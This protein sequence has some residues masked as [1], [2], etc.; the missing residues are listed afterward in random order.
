MP[1]NGNSSEFCGGPNRLNIYNF[2]ASASSSVASSTSATSTSAAAAPT[3]WTNL[4]CYTDSV[5][6]RTLANPMFVQGAMTVE[7]CTTACQASG[8]ILSG[9][10]YAGEC[11]CD[12]TFKNGGGP[13]PDGSTGCNMPCSGN[14]A[15][16][17][18]GPNRLNMYSFGTV[19]SSVSASATSSSAS[20]SATATGL[21]TGWA[22][23]GCYVDNA[24]GRILATQRP[25][26]PALTIESC[27]QACVGL[28][29]TVAG[30][31]YST[32]CFC[33][34]FLR[35]GGALASSD[36]Q[37]GMAC[38]GNSAEKC[39]GPDRMSIYSNGTLQTFKPPQSQNTSLPGNWTYQGCL[40]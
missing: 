11:Y 6:A 3:G 22:Y 36:T 12:N 15:E 9:V 5:A 16:M 21:P 19:T 28:G 37:C 23:S 29:F 17:C 4:G 25:D 20:A 1:C 8:Y 13:A 40:Q 30:M 14:A 2:G 31:E 39:G 7:K 18:G 27:V 38:G 33:D 24:N 26:D 35:N 34:K 10:E 32:Q